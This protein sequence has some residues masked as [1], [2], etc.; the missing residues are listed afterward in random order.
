[1]GVQNI[2]KKINQWTRKFVI[3][4]G[5]DQFPKKRDFEVSGLLIFFKLISEK[6]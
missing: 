3:Y 4:S 6:D 1:M 2:G 5:S